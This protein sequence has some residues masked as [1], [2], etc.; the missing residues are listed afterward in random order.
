MS[1]P[2]VPVVP[3][4]IKIPTLSYLPDEAQQHV[5]PHL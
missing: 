2:A 4:K 3:C 1:D 5:S